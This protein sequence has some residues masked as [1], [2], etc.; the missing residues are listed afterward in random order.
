MAA[1]K[2]CF[3]IIGFGPKPDLETGRI[4]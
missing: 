1:K 2:K 4:I 3:V